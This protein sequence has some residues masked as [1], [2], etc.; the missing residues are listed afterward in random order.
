MKGSGDGKGKRRN[1]RFP[2][3]GF[4]GRGGTE[5]FD[6]DRCAMRKSSTR[7]H[8]PGLWLDGKHYRDSR[9][10]RVYFTDSS[11]G[12]RSTM[13][14]SIQVQ[15]FKSLKDVSA[16][17][18]NRNVLVGPNMAGKSN[19]VDVFR[20]LARMVLPGPNLYGLTKAI[21]EGG[22]FTE[23]AWKGG[24]SSLVSIAFDADLPLGTEP[25]A[26][27]HLR[28]AI[29]ILGDSRG[30]VRVQEETLRASDSAA[31]YALV[32]KE[33]GERVLKNPNGTTISRVLDSNRSALEFEIPDWRGNGFRRYIGSWRFYRL[34][35]Q[36]MK[37]ANST[38]ATSFLNELGENLSSWLMMLQTRH[39]E[40]F[41][42]VK[43]V[44]GDVFPEL[45]DLFTWPTQQA[46]VFVASRE[47]H[48]KQ[49]VSVWQMSDGQLAFIALLSLVYCPPELGPGLYCVEEPENHLHPRLLETLVE[50]IRQTQDEYGPNRSAQIIATTHSPHL[51][52]RLGLDELIVTE[53][54]EGE[55]RLTRPSDKQHLR[56]LLS[57]EAAGLGDLY[58]S[59]ALSGA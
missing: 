37:Q 39:P 33:G 13:I 59:G 51:V 26:P 5:R 41:A 24:D 29:S 2:G 36:L 54:H 12:M 55:T 48:L 15:N 45:E 57:R 1:T 34:I 52:D 14:R 30:G 27:A 17:L 35:P 42:K 32:D 25:A 49:P 23:L 3:A 53:R 21:A 31:T 18:Q 28:Y 8:L 16:N 20:F 10:T 46:T 9:R 38:V 58:Y 6:A 4:T 7:K 44:A 11:I 19:F 47:K 40:S 43:S 50:L 56:E 22:G